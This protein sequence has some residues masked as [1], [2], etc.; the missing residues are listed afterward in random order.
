M[1]PVQELAG[2]A[3]LDGK[4][5]VVLAPTAGG[6]TEASMF[7]TLSGL[8]EKA[9][10]AV[11]AVYVA[12]IKALLFFVLLT[13]LKLR[14]RTSLFT[15]LSLA[16]T[17][18]F[19]L[20]VIALAAHAGWLP[21]EWVVVT[22]VSVAVTFV[23]ASPLNSAAPTL[24][25]KYRDRIRRFETNER[26][27]DEQP[28]DVGEADILICG[29]GMVG[30]GAYDALSQRYGQRVTGIDFD[31]ETVA[32]QLASGRKVVAG[33]ATD[34]DF[35]EQSD[36]SHVS[37]IMLCIPNHAENLIAAERLSSLGFHGVLAGTALYDDEVD[38]LQAAGVEAAFNFFAEAGKGFADHVCAMADA[39]LSCVLDDRS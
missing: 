29:M 19:G 14:A 10:D 4:N 25:R 21:T 23:L 20:L 26:L 24:Y 35:W 6:K 7:P 36:V 18:E 9:P 38:E 8:V 3:I 17:S 12:P 30:I 39:D 1:R 15:S 34:I 22:A 27:D 11:G 28:I 37:L 31:G 16:S 32:K 5:A 13:R 2:E 33:D